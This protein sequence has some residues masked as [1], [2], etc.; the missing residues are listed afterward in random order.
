M[1]YQRRDL[2]DMSFIEEGKLVQPSREDYWARRK[3]AKLGVAYAFFDS[4]ASKSE[5]EELVL[6]E[7]R[8]ISGIPGGTRLDVAVTEVKNINKELSPELYEFMEANDIYP[9]FPSRF[10]DQM[11]DAKPI[12]MTDLKYHILAVRHEKTDKET[13]DYLGNVML[14]IYKRYGEGKPFN[15]AVVY[16][17]PEDGYLDFKQD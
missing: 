11:N 4:S 14:D 7:G 12:K 15:V 10:R 6:N 3:S 16:R 8:R 1:E 17:N 2:G 13:A 5:I 9:T